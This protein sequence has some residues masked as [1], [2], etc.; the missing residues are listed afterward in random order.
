[1]TR[2]EYERTLDL[3]AQQLVN[4]LG[5]APKKRLL[6]EMKA[7]SDAVAR[8]AFGGRIDPRG[9]FAFNFGVSLLFPAL[10]QWLDH[11]AEQQHPAVGSPVH[12]LRENNFFTE[13]RFSNATDLEALRG[14]ISINL[15]SYAVPFV[16]RYSDLST[17]R[18]AVTPSD[19]KA[20]IDLGL[21]QDSRICLLAVI[22]WVQG[23]KGEALQTLADACAE[24]KMTSPQ[25]RVDI[26]RL[27]RRLAE[28]RS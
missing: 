3:F 23:D 16:E 26:E 10:S 18:K 11:E 15:T 4:A 20:W 19:P 9:Y 2:S 8:I 13:W 5:F 14:E 22:Q 28:D 25:R 1:M 27:Q 24:R 7:S 17:L 12:L 6:Y 21:N